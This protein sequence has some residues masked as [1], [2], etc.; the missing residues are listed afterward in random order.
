MISQSKWNL[1]RELMNKLYINEN[2]IIENF[3]KGSGSGGQKIN[4]TSS[5]VQ[6][7][8]K[9]I[10]IRC[11]KTRSQADN[12]FWA[13]R[14]LCERVSIEVNENLNRKKREIE[15]IRR[16]KKKKSQRIKKKILDDKSRHSDKKALRK[17]IDSREF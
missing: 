9:K 8:Y 5:C 16:Q 11:Q 10:D 17:K 12:R 6:L 1:L 7:L 14:E 13:R 3:I 2:D 15:K 4:K